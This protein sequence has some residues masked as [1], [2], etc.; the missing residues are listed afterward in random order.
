MRKLTLIFTIS[1]FI[2]SFLLI[3]DA[4][5]K[6]PKHDEYTDRSL[7]GSASTTDSSSK[8]LKTSDV[9]ASSGK[10][11][12]GKYLTARYA[13][14]R[15]EYKEAADYYN[16]ALGDNFEDEELLNGALSN[17]IKAG[18]VP[19]ALELYARIRDAQDKSGV[20]IRR[21][22][23]NL[24][25]LEII[26]EIDKAN[27]AD[28][29]TITEDLSGQGLNIVLKPILKAWLLVGDGKPNEALE[30]IKKEEEIGNF[31][32]LVSYHKGLLYEY[33]GDYDGAEKSYLSALNQS[34]AKAQ[35]IVE[36][37][38]QFYQ[39]QNRPRKARDLYTSYA[40]ES[41]DNWF[42]RASISKLQNISSSK[43]DLPKPFTAQQGVA[44]IFYN[45]ASLVYDGMNTGYSITLLNFALFL[46]PE[47]DN[48]KMM[49]AMLYEEEAKFTEAIKIYESIEESS[50]FSWRSRLQIAECLAQQ[51]DVDQALEMLASMAA[52]DK[53]DYDAFVHAGDIY[54]SSTRYEMAIESYTQALA[55]IDGLKKYHWPIFFA[56]GV[57]YERNKQW[58]EA[59]NDFLKSLELNPEQPDVLNYLAYS[60]VE[61]NIKLDESIKML[62]KALE[63][64]PN[65]AHIIDSYGWALFR[66]GKYEEAAFQLEKALEISPS[67]AAIN[68]HLGDVYWRLNRKQEAR[69]QWQRA[70]KFKPESKL[71]LA[72]QRKLKKGLPES[73]KSI[74]TARESEKKQE[75]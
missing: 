31:L 43:A 24:A 62:E 44:E 65:E 57:S 27:F 35:R 58:P 54:R 3:L 6:D 21:S 60:W 20:K 72:I 51:G 8:K 39:R 71:I 25:Y 64:R 23:A 55:R 22:A 68:D 19:E 69:F 16:K 38:G 46:E 34:E 49:L 28:A 40:G 1:V 32:P 10:N 59:E 26:S 18:R 42:A 47:L 30:I 29:L 70:L 61:Q 36:V 14:R 50:I 56:R 2:C 52:L 67:D 73:Q 7:D 9:T 75:L 11:V 4:V 45:L 12:F 5:A 13:S 63:Q 41:P 48:A 37:L 74:P 33:L 66:L 17:L 15:G 53:G